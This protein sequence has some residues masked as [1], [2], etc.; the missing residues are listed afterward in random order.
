MQPCFDCSDHQVLK[1]HPDGTF[2]IKIIGEVKANTSSYL[3]AM[4]KASKIF[5]KLNV[6]TFKE[7]LDVKSEKKDHFN[8]SIA[9]CITF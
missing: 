6:P 8:R 1:E 3:R 7:D 2:E 4:D 9:G 5:E